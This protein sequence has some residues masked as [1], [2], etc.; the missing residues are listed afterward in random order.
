MKTVISI[1][2]EISPTLG[3]TIKSVTKQV[4]GISDVALAASAAIVAVGKATLKSGKYL[5][6]LGKKFDS[7]SDAIRIGTGATGEALEAL[8]KD[9]DAVYKSVPTTMEN[10]RL[11]FS[12]SLDI[13]DVPHLHVC[14]RELR[15][16][17]LTL[18][19]VWYSGQ[20]KTRYQAT[21]QINQCV[22]L[23]TIV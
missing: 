22:G 3:K 13:Q 17:M 20:R 18:P 1:A 6:D 14:R 11:R 16:A 23:L 12:I 5:T 2:G 7:A 21:F 15:C 4:G 19:K 8:N 9:F 10:A